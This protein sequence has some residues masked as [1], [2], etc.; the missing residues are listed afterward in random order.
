ML[1]K[2]TRSEAASQALRQHLTAIKY[3]EFNGLR[4]F[5]H[6]GAQNFGEYKIDAFR[7]GKL[8][9]LLRELGTLRT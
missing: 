8:A 6:E 5:D 4:V 3:N 2:Y 1:G 7:K 9:R